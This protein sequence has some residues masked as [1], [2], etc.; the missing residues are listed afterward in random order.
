[1]FFGA[2]FALLSGGLQVFSP[3][4]ADTLP[5]QASAHRRNVPLSEQRDMLDVAR[6]LVPFL[7]LKNEKDTV[8][9][10]VG[11]TFAWILPEAGYS[12][13]ARL[14]VEL[15]GNIVYRRSGENMS[16]IIPTVAYS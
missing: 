3:A 15:Q 2:M 12:L 13:Q 1:M 10:P 14:L 7:H 11:R 9:L 16:T 6:K 5:H 8:T 4:P